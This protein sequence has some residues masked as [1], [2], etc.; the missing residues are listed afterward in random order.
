MCCT[1]ANG[2]GILKPN[3]L[4]GA[5]YLGV[6]RIADVECNKWSKEETNGSDY[7]WVTTDHNQIPRRL[8]QNKGNHTSDYLIHTFTNKTFD[9]ITF[10]LPNYCNA[11]TLCPSSS[12][13]GKY[14][15]N[16]M[17]Q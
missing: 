12:L 16:I 10:A 17:A 13:C 7:Y 9:D 2:C 5:T 8:E 4:D 15:Q 6:E 11:T 14:Q 1:S 3:W